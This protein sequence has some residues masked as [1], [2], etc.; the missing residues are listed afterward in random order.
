ML[1]DSNVF[2]VFVDALLPM[3]ET[4]LSFEQSLVIISNTKSADKKIILLANEIRLLV[5]SGYNFSSA[6]E[7]NEVCKVSKSDIALILSSEKCGKLLYALKLISEKNKRNNETRSRLQNA[8]VYPIS[9]VVIMILGTVLLFV[10][11]EKI[12]LSVQVDSYN[13]IF[14]A[15]CFLCLFAVLFIKITKTKL[16]DDN[17]FL[18]F[19]TLGFYLESGFDT[20][21]A[22]CSTMFC[23]ITDKKIINKLLLVK[24]NIECGKSLA[25]AFNEAKMFGDDVLVQLEISS[26]HGNL[27]D[28][29]KKIALRYKKNHDI[30]IERFIKV[31]EPFLL[32]AAG[33]YVL[34]ILQSTIL[35]IM[36]NW[37]G[38]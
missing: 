23:G 31:S 36:L 27:K 32:L 17:C 16:A 37:G 11:G 21:T 34:I 1:R 33:I 7:I 9:V 28:T 35:P 12:G 30:K 18:V 2:E 38:L 13:K 22:I 19:S 5:E 10:F 25:E 24:K 26:T 4:G 3:L 6:V 20:F 15:F 14:Y 29:C 8:A